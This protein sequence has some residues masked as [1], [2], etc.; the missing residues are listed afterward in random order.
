[1][2][3]KT[4]NHHRGLTEATDNHDNW[5]KVGHYDPDFV[6][7]VHAD[8]DALRSLGPNWDGYGAPAIDPRVIDAAKRFI[9]NLPE[10]L[11]Y[12]PRVVPTSNGSLQFEWHEG[13]KCL[14]LE[15]E[16]PRTIHYLQWQPERDI[17][18]EN[19]IAVKDQDRAIDLINWFMSGSCL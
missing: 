1:M 3:L 9:A 13:S 11:A 10:N 18:E 5:L 14:E 4:I 17:E 7:G 8:I 6:V 2:S 12:R 15:F 16:S 19:T